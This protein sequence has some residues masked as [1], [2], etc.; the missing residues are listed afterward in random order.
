MNKNSIL[1]THSI[2]G[3]TFFSEIGIGIS[4]NSFL[5]LVHILKF[6]RGHRP[7]LTDLPI[8]LLSL[9]HLLML[10]VAAFIAT[11]IFISR[12]GWDDIIC[13]FLVYLYRVLRGFSLCTTSMLSILQAIILSPRSSC[14]AKFKH[15]SP[16]HISGAILFLSV[17]YMLIGS[18]LLVSI[19]ATPNLTMNDF[20]YV[21]QSCSILP[22]SYLMQ[23]IYSTLLAIREFFLISLM[24]LSNWYMVALLSMHRKQTQHLHGTNLSPKKSPEQSATQ[25]ILML[26]SFF[27]L[28][29]IYDTIVSCSRTMFLNDPTSYSIELFIMHIY[30]TVSPFVFMSTEKH[31][32]NF[33]RSLGKRVINFNLH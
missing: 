28:M 22:L 7:R 26:I 15:I 13:K 3:K 24:V 10:L 27:L 14:L 21:T 33:L 19:I 23:S 2:I 1:H 20:I 25:T 30:A 18:Q 4:G 11:D 5:L 32:V 17:L 12:R 6:I 9:I 8:G 31:I 29:T 16:H